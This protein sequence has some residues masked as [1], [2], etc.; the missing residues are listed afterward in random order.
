MVGCKLCYWFGSVLVACKL[1]PPWPFTSGKTRVNFSFKVYD[2]KVY[3][4]G[5]VVKAIVK[6]VYLGK[7]EGVAMAGCK[8]TGK[9]G[10]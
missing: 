6:W 5:I 8:V 2:C 7:G 1:E 3:R 10:E 9:F 4:Q